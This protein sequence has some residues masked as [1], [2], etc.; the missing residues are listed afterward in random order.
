[1]TSLKSLPDHLGA[2][3]VPLF[4]PLRGSAARAKAREDTTDSEGEDIDGYDY[5]N[6]IFSAR[7]YRHS[8]Y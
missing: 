6:E 7:T 5:K 3:F 8:S 4:S 2:P 1:M